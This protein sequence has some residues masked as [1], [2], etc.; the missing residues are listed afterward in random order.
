MQNLRL[1]TVG[2]RHVASVER[3]GRNEDVGEFDE[4]H[5]R[6]YVASLPGTYTVP[7]PQKTTGLS[8]AF[9]REQFADRV[10]TRKRT[11]LAE[12][13]NLAELEAFRR[14]TSEITREYP[15]L[16]AAYRADVEEI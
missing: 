6:A 1:R 13:N 7:S 12:D 10:E 11:L 15:S 3:G 9:A 5:L 4:A 16:L 8:T 2:T 14:A